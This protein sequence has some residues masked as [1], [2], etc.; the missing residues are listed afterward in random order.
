M[1]LSRRRVL[2][3]VGASAL[4]LPFYQILGKRAH[5]QQARR[6]RN[7]FLF[8]SPNGVVHNLWR[9]Q[10][11]GESFEILDQQVLT[12]LRPYRDDLI[13]VDGLDFYTGNNHEGGME[14]MLTNGQGPATMGR[15]VD[16]VIASH[17]GGEDRF[18]SL[19]FGILT[20]PW[21]ASIQTRMCYSGPQQWLHPDA[22]PQSMYRRMFGAVSTDEQALEQIRLRRQSV[23]DLVRGELGDLQRRLGQIERQKLE[24]HLDSIRGMERSLFPAQEGA[25]AR[26]TPPG[27]IGVNDYSS[28]PQITRSQ[29]DLAVTALACEMTHVTTVQLSHTVSPVVFSWVGNTSGHHTLSHAAD[30][31]VDHLD[32]LLAAEQWCASQ[33]AYAIQQMKETPSADGEGTLFDETLCIWVKELGDS[34]LHVCEDVP[35]VIAGSANQRFRTGRYLHGGGSSHSHLLVSLCQAFGLDLETFGDPSTG[36]GPLEGLV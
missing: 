4:A 34:R 2:R 12:P 3:Q 26:P 16:Q 21:G 23:I 10:V 1:T 28:V 6:P 27:R 33:F 36:T 15:S 17:I 7:L 32:Q 31:N 25:C 19:E 24:R 8:F 30:G 14:A 20:D 9:P 22:N 35:F 13:I 5:A 11:A 18:P 29:I